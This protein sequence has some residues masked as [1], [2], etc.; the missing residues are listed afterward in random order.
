MTVTGKL[1]VHKL[2][3]A[4][5]KQPGGSSNSLESTKVIRI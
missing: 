3:F 5:N 4:D 2:N 1:K